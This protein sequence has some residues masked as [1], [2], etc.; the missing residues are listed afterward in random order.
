[1][2][3]Y[4][5]YI[6]GQWVDSK[7]GKAFQSI[8][9]YTEKPCAEVALA[10]QEDAADAVAAA[11][12]S[13]DEGKWRD[14]KPDK[15]EKI[16]LE[17]IKEI[18]KRSS[19][20]A[21]LEVQ[22]SGSTLRKAMG[23]VAVTLQ[24]LTFFAN[25]GREIFQDKPL[26]GD[27]ALFGYNIA[28]REPIGVC[29]CIIPWNFPL[30]MAIWKIGP[31]LATG[32]SVVLK[33][34]PETP[35]T[36]FELAKIIDESEIPKG[37]LN[38]VTGDAEV[39]EAI[40]T[41]PRVDKVAF[42][43]ST[44]VG[45]RIMELAAKQVKKVTL[46]LGGKSPNI[47]LDDADL[48][49]AVDGAAFGCFFHTGQVCTS[50]SRLFLQEKIYDKFVETLVAKAKKIKQ[51]DPMDF[52]TGMGPLVSAQHRERVERYIALGKEEGATLLTGG[53]RPEHLKKGFFVEPTIFDNVRNDM[54]IAQEEIFGPV[55]SILRFKR[56]DEAVKLANDTIYGLAGAVWSKNTDRALS[57]ARKIQTGTI[58]INE[59][60]ILS[61]FAPFGGYKQSGI[62]KELGEDGLLAY[63]QT[64]HVH[65]DLI[66]DRS[67][68]I[69]YDM[70]Y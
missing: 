45:R 11:R 50:G 54:R 51:G 19:E 48:G 27:G 66:G 38:V 49:M 40:V 61:P 30:V 39:G 29:G 35:C 10:G 17:V 32:N 60:H 41:D 9:P 28:I 64:K 25:K 14:A 53:K 69:W 36:A 34:A 1:M 59:Y 2:K 56:E 70:I 58:W 67:R 26:S 4:K 52:S 12:K 20:L 63:T 24:H 22:D 46:E 13:F 68:K 7:S 23:D 15:R 47:V 5:L 43:G 44:A 33:P 55:I 8:N 37:V 16:L 6:N 3:Q 42:T 21:Q 18:T 31:A 65:I 62:G 57:L